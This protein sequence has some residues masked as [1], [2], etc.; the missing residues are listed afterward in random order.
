[1]SIG[2]IRLGEQAELF[3]AGEVPGQDLALA[4]RDLTGLV[5]GGK[6]RAGGLGDGSGVRIAK[7]VRAARPDARQPVGYHPGRQESLHRRVVQQDVERVAAVE[8]G[9]RRGV[10]L[11]E[12]AAGV[13]EMV[14][15]RAERPDT[16]GIR[17][18]ELGPVPVVAMEEERLPE[19]FG[20]AEVSAATSGSSPLADT[21][22]LRMLR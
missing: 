12:D 4:G 18:A 19:V 11:F 15:C 6:G 20:D 13:V 16:A 14:H 7:K 2:A 5:V 21:N 10:Q 17:A 1:M 9:R 8:G 22:S 3:G